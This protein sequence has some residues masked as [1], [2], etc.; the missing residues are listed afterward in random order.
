MFKLNFFTPISREALENLIAATTHLPLDTPIQ[1]NMASSG[2][3]VQIGMQMYNYLKRFSNLTIKAMG[4]IDSIAVIVFLAASSRIAT[5]NSLFFLHGITLDSNGPISLRT[6]DL[7]DY[8]DKLTHEISRY[9]NIF[10]KATAKAD[11][12]ISLGDIRLILEGHGDRTLTTT[13]ALLTGILSS[14]VST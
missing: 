4:N 7:D 1:I 3:N 12:P 9:S 5:D 10:A 2:G 8:K 11:K 13:E 14:I 6:K